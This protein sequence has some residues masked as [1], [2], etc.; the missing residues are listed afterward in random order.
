MMTAKV[1]LVDTSTLCLS[2]VLH[3]K[4]KLPIVILMLTEASRSIKQNSLHARIRASLRRTLQTDVAPR[5]VYYSYSP[6]DEAV[7][8][9]TTPTAT[10]LSFW[11]HA[12]DIMRHW[13]TQQNLTCNA[14]PPRYAP[15]TATLCKQMAVLTP[16]TTRT[17]RNPK[18]SSRP[19]HP[20]QPVS[21]FGSM[22][23]TSCDTGVRS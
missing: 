14:L 12:P 11:I 21:A 19:Q 20:Q 7:F 4:L 10:S 16:S 22:H 2:I 13:S 1:A 5:T 8:S 18:Q 6:Q 9:T 23:Q 3:M 17:L 15:A